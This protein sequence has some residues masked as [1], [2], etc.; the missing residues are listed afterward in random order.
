[1]QS[2][3]QNDSK[4]KLSALNL[5]WIENHFG[6]MYDLSP[7]EREVRVRDIEKSMGVVYTIDTSIL[8]P[9]KK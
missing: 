7:S 1:M 3:E 4:N 9:I 2:K 6:Q 8:K 5:K